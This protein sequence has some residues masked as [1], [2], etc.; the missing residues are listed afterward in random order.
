[1][2]RRFFTFKTAAPKPSEDVFALLSALPQFSIAR[3]AQH[4]VQ[5]GV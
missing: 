3:V 1:M 5:K 4:S 2:L